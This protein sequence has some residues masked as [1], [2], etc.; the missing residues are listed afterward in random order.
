MLPPI[1]G[2][3]HCGLF[4]GMVPAGPAQVLPPI[5][6]GLHCGDIERAVLRSDL[7]VLPPILGGL[8]CGALPYLRSADVSWSWCTVPGSDL[9]L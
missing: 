7:P 5:L 6:G 4:E 3:L 8:H 9:T 1:L 2:G